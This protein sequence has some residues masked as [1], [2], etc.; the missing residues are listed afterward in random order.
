MVLRLIPIRIHHPHRNQVLS[1]QNH[2]HPRFLPQPLRPPIPPAAVVR[3]IGPESRTSGFSSGNKQDFIP[4]LT[5]G[6][7]MLEIYV[8]RRHLVY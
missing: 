4:S 7:R 6:G 2:F 5:W 3:K 8:Q 1:R